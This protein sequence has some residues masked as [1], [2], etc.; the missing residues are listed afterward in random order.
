MGLRPIFY[1]GAGRGIIPPAGLSNTVDNELT[2]DFYPAK[3][4]VLY[5]GEPKKGSDYEDYWAL[6][7]FAHVSREDT[8]LV[9]VSK[10]YPVEVLQRYGF[11]GGPIVVA[12]PAEFEKSLRDEIVV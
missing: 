11:K 2:E 10:D 8:L 5:L 4:K 7:S 6:R 3:T 9:Y 1:S 12:N